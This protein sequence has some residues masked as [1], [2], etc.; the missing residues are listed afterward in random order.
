MTDTFY[1][2]EYLNRQ[3]KPYARPIYCPLRQRI[4]QATV[5]KSKKEALR[6]CK[7]FKRDGVNSRV[8][9]VKCTAEAI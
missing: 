1:I 9:R 6:W 2:I 5:I 8:L 4:H 3:D 7:G